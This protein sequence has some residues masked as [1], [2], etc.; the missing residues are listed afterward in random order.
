[1]AMPAF[2]RAAREAEAGGSSES[3]GSLVSTASSRAGRETSSGRKKPNQ[4][5]A[6]PRAG[7][8][9]LPSV[10][11]EAGGELQLPGSPQCPPHL[12][13]GSWPGLWRRPA[14]SGEASSSAHCQGRREERGGV[15]ATRLPTTPAPGTCPANVSPSAP[16]IAG[17]HPRANQGPL[18]RHFSG[19]TAAAR[20]LS[21]QAERCPAKTDSHGR[22]GPK[23]VLYSGTKLREA[24][25]ASPP[26]KRKACWPRNVAEPPS[27]LS[28]RRCDKHRQNGVRAVTPQPPQV[29]LAPPT[30]SKRACVT[31]PRA[32][33]Q[34]PQGAEPVTPGRGVI[35]HT[36]AARRG[37]RM[38][39]EV[40]SS[41]TWETAWRVPAS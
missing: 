2:S 26:Q 9:S 40:R 16:T 24:L 38:K 35:I 7:G 6:A 41:G 19:E 8:P 17:Q 22:R 33:P 10:F 32:R 28:S 13:P 34:I 20:V 11:L 30:P 15:R 29:D 31:E 36:A 27:S 4:N 25:P 1:M 21:P 14:D 18:G 5:P 3:Q 12:P 23:P 39:A 37:R